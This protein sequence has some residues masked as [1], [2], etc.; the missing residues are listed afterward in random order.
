MYPKMTKDTG[1]P[2]NV[3]DVHTI[4]E[5]TKEL[6]KHILNEKNI[7]IIMDVHEDPDECNARIES[8][9]KKITTIIPSLYANHLINN[10]APF[11]W[12][13]KHLSTLDDEYIYIQWSKKIEYEL[14][15]VVLYKPIFPSVPKSDFT[16][17]S[18]EDCIKRHPNI[19]NYQIRVENVKK[20]KRKEV[21][22]KDKEPIRPHNFHDIFTY[23][24][25]KYESADGETYISYINCVLQEKN[26]SIEKHQYPIIP[27]IK[28]S[29]TLQGWSSDYEKMIYHG[30]IH[31]KV[32]SE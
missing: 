19:E 8:I 30:M 15:D 28:V 9:L 18:I 4:N 14:E 6:T 25:I 12:V 1:K 29:Y 20:I 22:I 11:V 31:D 21:V 2:K 5:L 13:L 16:Y 10:T 24:S 17:Y 23:E 27:I 3:V 32:P 26:K 7:K